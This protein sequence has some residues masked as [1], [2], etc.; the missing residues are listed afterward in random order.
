LARKWA[1]VQVA[2][3]GG[4]QPLETCD[5]GMTTVGPSVTLA[6]ACK[7]SNAIFFH[8]SRAWSRLQVMQAPV[9]DPGPTSPFDANGSSS[10]LAV[11]LRSVCRALA[12][13]TIRANWLLPRGLHHAIRIETCC[14][15]NIASRFM[16]ITLTC[17]AMHRADRA[18]Y[19]GADT[20]P[21]TRPGALKQCFQTWRAQIAL[22][23]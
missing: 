13:S 4:L 2:A 1:F 8:R 22:F 20:T 6:E 11:C 7:E 3:D 19:T 23:V 18:D 14:P 12:R 16:L 5:P 15:L 10:W 17:S 9:L 21:S